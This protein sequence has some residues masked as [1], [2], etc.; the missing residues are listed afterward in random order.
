MATTAGV[1]RTDTLNDAARKYTTLE[2]VT[3]PVN[4]RQRI[5]PDEHDRIVSSHFRG[6][7]FTTTQ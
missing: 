2:G 3:Q 5:R 4:Q 1:G 7:E 6:G